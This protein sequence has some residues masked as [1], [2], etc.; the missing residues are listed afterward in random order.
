MQKI[1][2]I[3][4]YKDPDYIRAITLRAALSADKG[5]QVVVIKN[6]H[7]NILRYP[8]VVLRLVFSRLR[9]R[10]DVYVLTFRGYELLPFFLLATVGKKRV[11][12]EFINLIEWVVYE[13]KKISQ[14]SVAAKMLYHIYRFMLSRNNMVLADT[15]AHARYS[16]KLMNLP[17][18]RFRAIPVSTDEAVFRPQKKARKAKGFRVFY[19]GNMLPLHG[20]S[21]VIEAA[22]L[23]KHTQ[24]I[25]FLLVGGKED[26]SKQVERARKKGARIDYKAWVPYAELPQTAAASSLCLAGPF[27]DTLQSSMVVTGKTYQFLSLGA[28]T[29][30]GRTKEIPELV[31]EVNCLVVPQGDAVALAQ[32]ISWAHTHTSKL[33]SIG[34][35][36]RM[37]YQQHYS[38]AVIAKIMS[39]ILSTS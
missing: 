36:G 29:L 37:V 32:K 1:C 10:H 28:P 33:R 6:S 4:C 14:S 31:D 5:N 16:A 15:Q 11:F 18:V 23:L 17:L 3:T 8:E 35:G 2:V 9:Y 38:N 25:T 34:R 13:H 7:K 12:D 19:Y 20:L 30:I 26:V 22:L 24:D 39:S 27:G 21:Y